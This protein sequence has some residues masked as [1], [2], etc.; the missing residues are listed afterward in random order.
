MLFCTICGNLLLTE[1]GRNSRMQYCC[2]TCPFVKN[3][4]KEYHCKVRTTKKIQGDVL[5]DEAWENVDRTDAKCPSCAHDQAY[6]MQ[7]QIRSADEPSTLFYK[8]CKCGSQWN[9]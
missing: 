3:V 4:E 5:G 8:C 1:F 7:I 6:F 9:D 2:T